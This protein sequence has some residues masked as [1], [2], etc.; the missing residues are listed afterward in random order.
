MAAW[1]PSHHQIRPLNASASPAQNSVQNALSR[2]DG[3]W[4]FLW[5][6][7]RSSVSRMATMTANATQWI[8]WIVEAASAAGAAAI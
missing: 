7:V 5:K 1:P 3:S 8:I 2:S 6:T 4:A